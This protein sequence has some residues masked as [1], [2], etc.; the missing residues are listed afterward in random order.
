[1]KIRNLPSKQ[2]EKIPQ[3]AMVRSGQICPYCRSQTRVIDSALIYRGQSYGWAVA[4]DKFPA[5]DSYVGCHPRSQRPL[6]R[7]ADKELRLAKSRAHE[8]LDRLWKPAG[9]RSREWVQARRQE[10]Y[11]WLAGALGVKERHCHVGMF[12]VDMCRKVVEVCHEKLGEMRMA[13]RTA[14]EGV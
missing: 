1:M 8:A 12:D 4:C 2:P 13:A 5:C 9:R 10:A 11:R 7:L 3:E 14:K 6:G